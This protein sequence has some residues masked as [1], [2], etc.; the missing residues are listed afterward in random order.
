MHEGRIDEL[1]VYVDSPLAIDATEV[2]RMHPDCYDAD[3]QTFARETGD[4]LGTKCCTFTRSVEQS[5]ALNQS[6]SPC[7]II[8]ASGMCE[9]GRILNH[10]K[11]NV[12]SPKN[13]ILIVGFQAANTLGRRIVEKQEFLNIYGEKH[14]LRAQVVVM[15]GFSS[16]AHQ[17]EILRVTQPA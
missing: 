16:H 2:F 15:D 12:E 13:T 8:A 10:L 9:S 14:R 5:K 6:R 7:I 11:N 1:P 3:A 4:L 17:D